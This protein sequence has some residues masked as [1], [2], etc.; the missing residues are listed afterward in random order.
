MQIDFTECLALRKLG[1]FNAEFRFDEHGKMAI[2]HHPNTKVNKTAVLEASFNVLKTM[3]K[4]PMN[5]AMLTYDSQYNYTFAVA[6][7]E[8]KILFL[9]SRGDLTMEELCIKNSVTMLTSPL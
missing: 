6:K 3:E 7:M 2:H 8:K 1:K 5:E 9:F 4:M